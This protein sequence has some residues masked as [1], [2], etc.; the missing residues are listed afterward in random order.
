M[1]ELD[2]VGVYN[3]AQQ[4]QRRRGEYIT[5][6]PDWVWSIDAHCKLEQFGIQIYAAID[7][8]S[9][10]IIW[11]YVGV[12]ARTMISVFKQF[13]TA[14]ESRGVTPRLLRAD[15]GY[16]TMITADAQY[17]LARISRTRQDPDE[18]ENCTFRKT[19]VFGT[20]TKNQRIEAWWQ[21]LSKSQLSAWVVSRLITNYARTIHFIQD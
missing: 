10:H 1:K 18:E 17:H 13:L 20:S 3:R 2:P 21:Q 8:Y 9:R 16:E 5:R 6:G 19:F 7:A 12:T 4:L 11:C 15:K 14:V